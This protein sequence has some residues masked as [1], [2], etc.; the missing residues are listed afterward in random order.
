MFEIRTL[1]GIAA[2]A[3]AP[4]LILAASAS[5]QQPVVV[6]KGKVKPQPTPEV[7][8]SIAVY[9]NAKLDAL[10]GIDIQLS[11]PESGPLLATTGEYGNTDFYILK[12]GSH[13]DV[14]LQETPIPGGLAL[15]TVSDFDVFMDGTGLLSYQQS[16][17][18]PK[19]H[20]MVI[21]D[22]GTSETRFYPED[23]SFPFWDLNVLPGTGVK[24][25]ADIGM[26]VNGGVVEE[27]LDYYGYPGDTDAFQRGLVMR[28]G[29]P[30][31]ATLGDDGI[32]L[33]MRNYDEL[34]YN[35]MQLDVVHFGTNGVQTQL[36]SGRATEATAALSAFHVAYKALDST[37]MAMYYLGGD[38]PE[39]YLFFLW[40]DNKETDI[41]E[42]VG[43]P[44]DTPEFVG[45]KDA[46]FDVVDMT[47][48]TPSYSLACANC[49]PGA[50]P[51]LDGWTCDPGSPS[52]WTEFW[53]YGC[54][55]D[56]DK[57]GGVTCE[58]WGIPTSPIFCDT[59][60]S[61]ELCVTTS[62][63]FSVTA[64]LKGGEVGGEVS[65]STSMS[66]TANI[67]PGDNGCGECV[68]LWGV[69][70]ICAQEFANKDDVVCNTGGYCF[71]HTW[72]KPCH[73]S[74][75]I[76]THCVDVAIVVARCSRG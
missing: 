65:V 38:M 58:Q 10:S 46:A 4:L 27:T 68:R 26:L 42:V 5:G 18:Q 73:E 45:N 54:P 11:T 23:R 21:D 24:F 28:V 25:E 12:N 7:F 55:G 47:L 49:D 1:P 33:V 75:P 13:V 72:T 51:A 34:D 40:R 15:G 53:N 70:L 67:E 52:A 16:F 60:G 17:A 74:D 19:A 22:N 36:D 32:A 48:D 63:S 43:F 20:S 64:K 44:L 39:G 69:G 62:A 57:V 30:G 61:M 37:E 76:F 35:T 3:V 6:A 56:G 66:T 2:L 71:G 31:G 14:A 8:T 50:P 41:T 9:D 59:N 29:T